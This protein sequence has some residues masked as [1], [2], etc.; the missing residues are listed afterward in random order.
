VDSQLRERFQ[1]EAKPQGPRLVENW[2]ERQPTPLTQLLGCSPHSMVLDCERVQLALA[3]LRATLM[4]H[5]TA[6]WPEGCLLDSIALFPDVNG[7]IDLSSMLG[8]LN[9]PVTI[10]SGETADM[11]MD[12]DSVAVSEEELQFTYGIRNLTLYRLGA[13]FL[14]IGLWSV[15]D[16]KDVAAVRRK[17][18]ALDSLGTKFR[19]AVERL[20]YGDF[21]VDTTDLN[22]ERLQV[23]I[24]RTVAAPLERRAKSRRP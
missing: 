11:D 14:S 1:F 9:I 24:L 18:A 21:G 22:D 15:V 12:A 4:N 10:G 8:T 13:A 16:W 7:E 3:I 6:S 20:L 2:D 19:G 5:S 23:E 17:A